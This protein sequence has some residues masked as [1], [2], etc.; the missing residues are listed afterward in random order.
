MTYSLYLHIPF[1]VH[2]CG[3]CDFNT[4]AGLEALIPAY[5]DALVREIEQ[6]AAQ[7]AAGQPGR[8]PAHTIFFGGGTPSLLPIPALERI[9]GALRASFDLDPQAEITLE[10]NPGTLSPEYLHALHALGV[11]RLSLGVQSANPGELRL[12]ERQ[13]DF[14]DVIRSVTWARQAGFDNLSLDLIFG[15]PEQSLASWQR[16]LERVLDLQP[17]HLSLYALTIEHGTPFG[18]WARRGLL[19]APDPDAAAEMYEW[20]SERLERSGY[21]PYEISNWAR[22]DAPGPAGQAAQRVTPADDTTSPALACRHNLQYWH[23]LPYLG[24]GAGA[25]G[26]AA[27]QR[28]IN[29]LSPQA[30]IQRLSGQAAPTTGDAPLAEPATSAGR[31][32]FPITAATQSA[33]PIDRAAEIGETMMMGLRLVREGVS[34]AVFQARFGQSLREVFPKQIEHLQRQ[35]LLEWAGPDGD[36]LRLTRRARLIAN[37]VFVEFI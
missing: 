13:H 28:T 34:D 5:T 18:H 16:S 32:P 35:G 20:A 19:S 17:E 7:A 8:L 29:T 14:P 1:C 30:Y 31:P 12:L 10:A 22:A 33:Q 36:R 37:R 26:Y 27:G 2:R 4:Y 6:A 3:Y 11:N 24:L 25:H 21:A 9:L 23:N 15:L